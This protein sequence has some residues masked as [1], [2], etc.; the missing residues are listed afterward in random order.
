MVLL[1]GLSALPG[2]GARGLPAGLSRLPSPS[3]IPFSDLRPFVRFTSP[4]SR[5]SAAP[6]VATLDVPGFGGD[7]TV[8]YIQA[9][10]DLKYA[11]DI[12]GPP[13]RTIVDVVLDAGQP[14]EQAQR[15]TSPPWSGTFGG[16]T[17]GEH[18]LDAAL[19]APEEGVPPAIA[20]AEPP[21]AVSHLGGVARGDVIAALGDSITEGIGDGPFAPGEFERLQSFPDWIAARNALQ[22][23]D[24]V[25]VSADGRNF[26]Q[27]GA[28]L[29]PL[30][31]PGFE[32]PLGELL[33]EQRRHPVLVI[34]A[35]WSGA[36]SASYAQ[37]VASDAFHRLVTAARPNIVLVNL[38]VNDPLQLHDAG[39]Y[40]RQMESVV[41]SLRA[42]V[43]SVDA[44]H[45]ACPS[46]GREAIRQQLLPTYLPVID[47]LRTDLGL[48]PAPDFYSHYRDHP[49]EL[50]DSAHPNSAGF[51]AMAQMWADALAG[52]GS[53]CVSA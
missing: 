50:V 3:P 8:P 30:S 48:G 13:G 14:D 34:N 19:Y 28:T 15:L 16:L 10:P 40:Q 22:A 33:A 47:H 2:S 23:L 31:L 44:I 32:V 25:A 36:T 21:V 38:G 37:I 7:F 52:H 5:V 45:L 1:L 20:L 29:H 46:Y 35:G 9:S 39:E 11:L 53:S 51:A 27:P 42:G 18:T 12:N 43:V 49:A 4:A 17:F 24:P 6:G 41:G 26:P